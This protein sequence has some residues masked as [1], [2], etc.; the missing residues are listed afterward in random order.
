MKRPECC[1]RKMVK[2]ID[3]PGELD[4]TLHNDANYTAFH[5]TVCEKNKQVREEQLTIFDFI[6]RGD[7]DGV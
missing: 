3:Y 5:C 2:I 1:N 7:R 4:D 6:G